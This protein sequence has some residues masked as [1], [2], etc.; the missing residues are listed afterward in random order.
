V[1]TEIYEEGTTIGITETILEIGEKGVG[2]EVVVE[3]YLGAGEGPG[4]N[5]DPGQENV[6]EDQISTE[7]FGIDDHP[8][9]GIATDGKSGLQP[10]KPSHTHISSTCLSQSTFFRHYLPL[11]SIK[12]TTRSRHHHPLCCYIPAT[13]QVRNQVKVLVVHILSPRFQLLLPG[14]GHT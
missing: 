9:T 1:T 11:T 5:L 6:I 8:E 7:T 10:A 12:A 14:R 4:P 3:V 13:S 2:V